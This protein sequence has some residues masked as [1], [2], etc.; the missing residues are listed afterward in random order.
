MSIEVRSLLFTYFG[1]GKV[2]QC[3]QSVVPAHNIPNLI[4]RI[5]IYSFRPLHCPLV[6]ALNMLQKPFLS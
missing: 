4:H 2:I 1:I 3:A 6:F 5:T